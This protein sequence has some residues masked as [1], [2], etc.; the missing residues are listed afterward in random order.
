MFADERDGARDGGDES[1][2]LLRECTAWR[3]TVRPGL[4]YLTFGLLERASGRLGLAGRFVPVART[5]WLA[6]EA[7]S[8]ARWRIGRSPASFGVWVAR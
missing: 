5:R 3:R 7:L 1:R 8:V 2:R 4:G 6:H